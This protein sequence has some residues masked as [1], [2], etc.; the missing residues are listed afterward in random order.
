M[1]I[2][3]RHCWS[4]PIPTMNI[5]FIPTLSYLIQKVAG[6]QFNQYECV[7][8]IGIPVL[9]VIWFFINFKIKK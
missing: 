1:K 9:V 5:W 4:S 3:K 7:W 2:S 6:V 8:W